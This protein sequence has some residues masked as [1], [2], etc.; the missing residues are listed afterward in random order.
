MR[1]FVT[2]ATG[3]IG[4]ELRRHLERAGHEVRGT[5]TRPRAAQDAALVVHR[6]G[7][8]IDAG[9]LDGVDVVVHTAWDLAPSATARNLGG[10]TGWRDAAAKHGAHLLFVSSYSA[11][12][13][14]PTAYGRDK[15][16]A[17]ALLPA[18]TVV[19]PALV[20]GSG[21]LFGRLV[22]SVRRQP[23]TLMPDG[24]RHGVELIDV[25]DL[26]ETLVR[27]VVER[28]ARA[29]TLSAG[30]LPLRE[31]VTLIARALGRRRPTIV[32]VP[33]AL[34]SRVLGLLARHP[35]AA[36]AQ[37]RLLGYLENGRRT[38][39]STLAEV[40]GRPP[41][42]PATAIL[43]RAPRVPSPRSEKT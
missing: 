25:D 38:R 2:G 28:K 30:R 5:T 37:E 43:T 39:T 18:A 26:C 20:V 7:D 33:I 11:H 8:P 14:F 6:L 35:R 12:P 23:F 1:V 15:A 27:C 42:S 9:W 29:E 10:T 13:D 40:L 3:F 34:A 16:A 24:G 21:G 36:D 31:V 4:G 17:E 41:I 22:E 32:P 19:R